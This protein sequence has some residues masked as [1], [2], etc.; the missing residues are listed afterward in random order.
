[1]GDPEGSCS[2]WD[3]S[4][5]AHSALLQSVHGHWQEQGPPAPAVGKMCHCC[6]VLGEPSGAD[7]L[8][9]PPLFPYPSPLQ[10]SP[11]WASASR[12]AVAQSAPVSLHEHLLAHKHLP[13]LQKKP[14]TFPKAENEDSSLD[15]CCPHPLLLLGRGA[16]ELGE[17]ETEPAQSLCWR[18]APLSSPSLLSQKRCLGQRVW[19]PTVLTTPCEISPFSHPQK[20]N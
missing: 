19:K 17:Q 18:G 7:S 12:G 6:A 11:S 4:H 13:V 15:R 1:M 8:S 14:R 9:S 20:P 10:L 5:P 16:R 3:R 2:P